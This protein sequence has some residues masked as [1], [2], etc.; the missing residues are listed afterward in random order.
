MWTMTHIDGGRG[1]GGVMQ[2]TRV[3]LSNVFM[4]SLLETDTFAVEVN[5]RDFFYK[6]A[7]AVICVIIMAKSCIKCLIY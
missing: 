4:V 6:T 2:L 7:T 3:L 5:C 1:A